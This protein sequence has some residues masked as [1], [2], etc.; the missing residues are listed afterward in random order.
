MKWFSIPKERQEQIIRQTAQRTGNLP[1]VI[2]KDIWVC[3]VLKVLFESE[4]KDVILFKGGTSLSKGYD[5]INRFSEDIDI[6]IDKSYLGF[7]E[8]LS[9]TQIDKLRKRVFGFTVEELSMIIKN[10][11]LEMGLT[12]EM[13]TMEPDEQK[14]KKDPVKLVLSYRSAFDDDSE[15]VLPR[16]LIEVSGRSM[17]EPKENVGINTEIFAQFKNIE[18]ASISSMVNVVVPERTCLEKMF[19]LHEEYTKQDPRTERM[20][21][22]LF[23][24]HKIVENIGIDKVLNAELF[25]KIKE[26]RS[27]YTPIKSTDYDSLSMQSICF[28]PKGE[29][30]ELFE[31]DYKLMGENMFPDG[32]DTLKYQELIDILSEINSK[33]NG[34]E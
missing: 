6:A 29:L 1:I 18:D 26:H 14:E 12:D 31:E 17:N 27:I 34:Y 8:P 9:N 32:E 30:Q 4:L 22:H 5:I 2:E 25:Y 19:L 20:S 15:Y 16:V 3:I 10:S 24:I 33:I 28:L 11:L 13:F 23:D 21:R 7:E